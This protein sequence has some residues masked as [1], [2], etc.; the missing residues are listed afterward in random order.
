MPKSFATVKHSSLSGTSEKKKKKLFCNLATRLKAA[1]VNNTI[2]GKVTAGRN[3]VGQQQQ[4]GAV[5]FD[6]PKGAPPGPGGPPHHHRELFLDFDTDRG[7]ANSPPSDSGGIFDSHCF[8]T[9]PRYPFLVL[10]GS[11][12][13]WE[14]LGCSGMFWEILGCSGLFWDV[15]RCSEMF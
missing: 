14:I 13:F 8:A 10:R 6:A 1:G 12:M 3:F 15:L 9:T 7:G 2:G 11:G 5:S 4:R